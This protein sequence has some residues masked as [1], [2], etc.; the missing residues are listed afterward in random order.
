MRVF[1]SIWLLVAA[2]DVCSAQTPHGGVPPAYITGH[3]VGDSARSV[4]I[5][6]H[7]TL[8]DVA[9]DHESV[10]SAVVG[11]DGRYLVRVN[12][13]RPTL[14]ELHLGDELVCYHFLI[15]PGDTVTVDCRRTDAGIAAE[16][17]GTAEALND[18]LDAFAQRY[19]FSTES[20]VARQRA[21]SMDLA[22]YAA[23]RD[24]LLQS[25]REFIAEY[26]KQRTPP[27]DLIDY[28]VPHAE[29]EWALDRLQYLWMHQY[30]NGR[31]GLV[32]HDESYLA[33]VI[34]IARRPITPATSRTAKYTL[35]TLLEI[36]YMKASDAAEKRGEELHPRDQYTLKHGIADTLFAG[37][38]RDL[39]RVIVLAEWLN[40]AQGS[41]RSSNDYPRVAAAIDAVD[42]LLTD[43]RRTAA[44]PDYPEALER[45]LA[46]ARRLGPGMPAPHWTLTDS[47][48]RR[49]SLADL[50]GKVVYLEFWATSCGPCIKELPA[51]KQLQKDLAGT[52]VAFVY[53]ST[54]ASSEIWKRFLVR[55]E[56]G[57]IHLRDDGSTGSDVA[58]DY[59]VSGIP[60]YFLIDRDGRIVSSNAPRPSGGAEAMIRR[61][62]E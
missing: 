59:G 9:T 22:G 4:Q 12:V 44:A 60:H 56:F 57:G 17:G 3:I 35:R 47:A 49:L 34:A 58:A 50:R 23:F 2:V 41:A 40:S 45:A 8:A 38:T 25:Q 19:S 32:A 21:I 28:I 6:Y 33:P 52:E 53:V 26:W 51:T 43:V 31:D 62:L 30:I 1:L 10:D 20:R 24:S 46:R 18:F 11:A 15:R 5:R 27:R 48:G 54:D 37:E 39:A 61:L 36:L 42:S 7:R 14:F 13:V 55:H 29:Y 16:I